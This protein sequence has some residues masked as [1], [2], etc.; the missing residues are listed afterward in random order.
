MKSIYLSLAALSIAA[1]VSS[2]AREELKSVPSGEENL[3]SITV[4][5]SEKPEAAPALETTRTY[6]SGGSVKWADSGE[7]LRVFEVATPAEGDPVTS[8]KASS[9]GETTDGGST[10]RFGVS[11]FSGEGVSFD[12]Y[13]FY[14]SSA[15]YDNSGVSSVQI[16][17]NAAQT[18]T[19]TS[20]DPAADL[21]IAKKVE[22]VGGRPESLNMQFAR[23]VAIGKMTIKNLESGDNVTKITFSA[24]DD[25]VAVN[26]AGRTAFNLG[27]GLPVSSYASNVQEKSIIL[28]YSALSLTAD[29]ATGMDSFFTCYPFSLAA[30]DSFKVIVE[31]DTHYFTKEVELSGVQTLAFKEGNISSFSV[32]MDGIAGVTKAV[33]LNYACL[34]TEEYAAA[35]GGGSYA[36]LT[37]D[38]VN[39]D[40]WESY[41]KTTSGAINLR[42]ASGT[43]DS[44]IKLPVFSEEISSVVVTLLETSTT[45]YLSLERGPYQIEGE[46]S[47][48][49]EVTSLSLSFDL[50][51]YH[52]NTMYL[53]ALGFMP[54]ISKIEVFTK[55][56]TRASLSAPATVSASL[57]DDDEDI[58]NSIDVSWSPITNAESYVITCH[59]TSGED[60][61]INNVTTNPYT[62][63]G[64]AYSMSYIVKVHACGD[65]YVVRNQYSDDTSSSSVLTGP[66]LSIDFLQKNDFTAT[67]GTYKP[68]SD[69]AASTSARYAGQTALGNSAIQL[70]IGNAD[71]PNGIVSTTS[72]GHIKKVKIWWNSNTSTGRSIKVFGKNT[73]YSGSADL[74]DSGL[75]GTDLGN[76]TC[77]TSTE[78]TIDSDYEYVGIMVPVSAVV[79]IDK[80]ALYWE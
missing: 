9:Q 74:Y 70:N 31:T 80:I 8:Q 16:K 64:L 47:V 57:N 61:V 53:R 35:G 43:N 27:T 65:L 6:L 78:L 45:H 34:T 49:K 71:K 5:A 39:G 18:P 54:K 46:G 23:M 73:A 25:G 38:K 26:L 33:N 37:V 63:T 69:V 28:D 48:K 13:A 10:M 40:K 17:T 24:K 3:V 76:I 42:N 21:L 62:V 29:D 41:A 36:N 30:G 56:D 15:Y 68:F 32:D 4:I 51:S 66:E 20:F 79:Y 14:P 1:L 50:S 44:Y 58:T 72:G 19:A 22:A 12:Y 75:K 2:C 52:Y 7:Y 55:N 60:V 77:G 11:G 67:N 59:P